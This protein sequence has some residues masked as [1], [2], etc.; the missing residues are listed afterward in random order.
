MFLPSEPKVGPKQVEEKDEIS[1]IVPD[2][3]WYY[4]LL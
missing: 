1:V 2:C 4:Y 3:F